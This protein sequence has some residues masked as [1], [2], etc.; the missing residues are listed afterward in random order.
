MQGGDFSEKGD[1][2]KTSQSHF[3][4]M[5]EGAEI[6]MQTLICSM[7]ISGETGKKNSPMSA[8]KTQLLAAMPCFPTQRSQN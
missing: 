5:K 7:S 3:V 8:F 2:T 6:R 4:H 1:C